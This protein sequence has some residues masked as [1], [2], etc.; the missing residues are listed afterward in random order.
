MER[1]YSCGPSQRTF[2]NNR[3]LKTG[4][5][6]A[7][8]TAV[9]G[10]FAYR[11]ADW[12]RRSDGQANA[13]ACATGTPTVKVIPQ[14]PMGSFDGGRTRNS[15]V[16]QI[17]NNSGAVQNVAAYFYKE[18]GTALEGV[19]LGAGQSTIANGVL[20]AASIAKD[21]VLVITGGGPP[22]DGVNGWAKITACGNV[23]ITAF[24]ELRD[25]P[26]DVLQSRVSVPASS[27]N[28]SAFLIPRVRDAAAGL[29]VGF[30]LVNTASGGTAT[31]TAELKN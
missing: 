23:S 19:S 31:L 14:M 8:A 17:V 16:I 21:G 18:D 3:L 7:A 13:V 5:L 29:D 26:S 30:A 10:L 15:T 28:M 1:P 6:A 27:P 20:Q 4:L 22:T 2:V 24:F 12:S 9:F 11:A 25:G